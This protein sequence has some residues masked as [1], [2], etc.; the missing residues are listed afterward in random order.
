MRF[1]NIDGLLRCS[2][3]IL[4]V[5]TAVVAEMAEIAA[6]WPGGDGDGGQ[7]AVERW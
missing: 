6:E 7:V 1:R 2:S 3:I 4:T 5:L